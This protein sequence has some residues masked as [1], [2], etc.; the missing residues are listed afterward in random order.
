MTLPENADQYVHFAKLND[1]QG[2][3]PVGYIIQFPFYV[4]ASEM[5]HVIFSS[6]EH[7][8]QHDDAYEI[9][10]GARENNHVILHKRMNG[11]VLAD[12]YWPNILSRY[13][14]TKFVFQIRNDGLIQI[15]SEHDIYNP[16]LTVFDPVPVKLKYVSAKS[17]LPE[18]MVFNYGDLMPKQPSEIEQIKKELVL[19]EYK[20]QEINPLWTHYQFKE[21]ADLIKLGKHYESLDDV[22]KKILPIGGMYKPPGH[23]LVYSVYTQG[24]GIVKFRLSSV[25]YP[26]VDKDIF[27]EIGE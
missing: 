3:H 15:F 5:A 17:L 22:Y 4:K 20:T 2:V 9:V 18:K 21:S 1:V 26:S 11:A 25:E 16:L 10:L 19:S 7:P 6:V 27:Y 23:S 12:V 14:R 8:T 24:V 13:K